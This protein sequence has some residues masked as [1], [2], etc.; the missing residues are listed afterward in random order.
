LADDS[1]T[2]CRLPS[3][4]DKPKT[5]KTHSEILEKRETRGKAE[6]LYFLATAQGF[7]ITEQQPFPDTFSFMSIH[8]IQSDLVSIFVYD[9]ICAED[10]NQNACCN[11][12]LPSNFFPKIIIIVKVSFLG[13]IVKYYKSLDNM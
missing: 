2:L 13:G 9:K 6:Q 3:N 1:T 11:V 4:V 8:R 7:L 12:C 10:L 5:R